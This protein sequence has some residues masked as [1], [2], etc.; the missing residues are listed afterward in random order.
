M[1]LHFH[2]GEDLEVPLR[3][4][5]ADNGNLALSA[6]VRLLLNEGLNSR[7]RTRAEAADAYAQQNRDVIREN[8]LLRDEIARLEARLAEK[9]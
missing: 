6:A 2:I 3:A 7:L 1:E 8:V 5:A 9:P 4:F